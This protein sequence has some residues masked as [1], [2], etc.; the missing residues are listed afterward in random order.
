MEGRG[1]ST[2][3]G[4]RRALLAS[5]LLAALLLAAPSARATIDLPQGPQLSDLPGADQV[6]N[7]S[8]I[9]GVPAI[10]GVTTSGITAT[11][12]PAEIGAFSSPFVEPGPEC[13]S[14]S[15]GPSDGTEAKITCKPAAVNIVAL[16]NGKILY[17]DGL[18]AEENVNLNVVAEIGDKAV[19]DQSRLLDLSGPSWSKPSPVDA[20]AD[21]TANTQYLVPNAPP[22]LD[23]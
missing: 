10:P 17:W 20:G 22:P 5:A 12:G 8:S 1:S 18:E 11:G 21:G 14:G 13:P 23:Q 16:P 2:A 3:T 7:V 9:P 4:I 6:P 15:S 19:N